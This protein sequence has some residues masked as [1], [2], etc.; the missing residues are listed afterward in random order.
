M[1]TSDRKIAKQHIAHLR[2]REDYLRAKVVA[3][4]PDANGWCIGEL[5][6]LAWALEHLRPLARS[7]TPN[8][9]ANLPP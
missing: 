6:A 3:A 5:H 7:K 1:K 8:V 9:R 2:R 4:G